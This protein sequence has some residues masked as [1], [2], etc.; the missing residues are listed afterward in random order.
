VPIEIGIHEGFF[1]ASQFIDTK[2]KIL[3]L[4][5]QGQPREK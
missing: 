3:F 4:P 2:V 1:G 5:K